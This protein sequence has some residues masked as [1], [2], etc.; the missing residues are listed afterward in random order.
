MSVN[1]RVVLLVEGD[2]TLY[3]MVTIVPTKRWTLTLPKI[4]E[5]FGVR[6]HFERFFWKTM[7]VNARVVLL[8]GRR[9]S[10]HIPMQSWKLLGLEWFATGMDNGVVLSLYQAMT[11]KR[12]FR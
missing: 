11:C 12:R 7:L 9:D 8:V 3:T 2:L 5:P 10:I 4:N 1:V 6:F